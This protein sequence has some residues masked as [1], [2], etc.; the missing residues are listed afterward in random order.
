M[1]VIDGQTASAIAINSVA[2]V[3]LYTFS[4]PANTLTPVGHRM[5]LTI[6]GDLV[7]NSGAS[8]TYTLVGSFGGTVLIEDALPVIPTSASRRTWQIDFDITSQSTSTS[9]VY[10]MTTSISAPVA[11]TVG[12]AGDF[13]TAMTVPPT[14]ILNTSGVLNLAAANT[15]LVQ[16]RSDAATATQTY[17]RRVATLEVD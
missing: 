10:S 17:T 11:A 7:N 3:T 15:L 16:V 13:G 2:N 9:S 6:Y 5:R 1:P 12:L 14:T 8:R 4:V